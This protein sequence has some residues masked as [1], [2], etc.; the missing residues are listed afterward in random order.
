MFSS[1]RIVFAVLFTS[2]ALL[3]SSGRIVA[4]E[5]A[6]AASGKTAV[7]NPGVA[8]LP[9]DITELLALVKGIHAYNPNDPDERADFERQREQKRSSRQVEAALEKIHRIATPADKDLPG[10]AD[11]MAL[12]LVFRTAILPPGPRAGTAN[13]R[14]EL[15]DEVG[16]MLAS[17]SAPPRDAIAAAKKIVSYFERTDPKRAIELYRRY[18]AILTKS[19]DAKAA[20][21]GA[22][23]EGAARRLELVGKPLE[24]SGTLFDGTKFDWAG[25]RGKV[26]LVDVWATWCGPCLRELPQVE[27]CYERYHVQGFEVVAISVDEDRAALDRFLKEKPLPWTVLHDGTFQTNPFARKYGLP[28]IPTMILVDREGKVMSIDAHPPGLEKLL[29]DQFAKDAK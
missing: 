3:H 24:L 25:Y 17:A 16:S 6:P 21:A 7:L 15:I 11:A 13:E 9:D 18:G 19:T 22:R 4:D 20:A 8:P 2:A 29:T 5:Q 28:G 12:R 1:C 14:E 27:K 23:M 26:V 10:F